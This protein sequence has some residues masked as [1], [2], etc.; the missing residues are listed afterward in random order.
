MRVMEQQQQTQPKKSVLSATVAPDLLDR[1]TT[2][3]GEREWSTAKTAAY[4]IRLGLEKLAEEKP[5]APREMAVA[6]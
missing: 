2:L 5:V 3:A 1:V 6:A 4:L